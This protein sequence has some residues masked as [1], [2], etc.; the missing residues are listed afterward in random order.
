[1]TDFLVRDPWKPDYVSPRKP[2][3]EYQPP[4]PTEVE[5]AERA[6]RDAEARLRRE[7]AGT[8][9]AYAHD[10]FALIPLD[11]DGRE[12]VFRNLLGEERRQI[13]VGLSGQL[14]TAE[15]ATCVSLA[16]FTET[17]IL[18]E[19][20]LGERFYDQLRQDYV[21]PKTVSWKRQGASG[22]CGVRIF[23]APLHWNSTRPLTGTFRGLNV[24]RGVTRMLDVFKVG[25]LS[26]GTI[27]RAPQQ[28]LDALMEGNS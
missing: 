21:I 9:Q 6:R 28:L 20:P 12:L 23:E 19:G 8:A 16:L 22:G 3:P 13:G 7:L 10:G 24:S 27:A 26:S 25:Q 2:L 1:M 4:V 14:F 15:L 18:L 5:L 17:S 11:A